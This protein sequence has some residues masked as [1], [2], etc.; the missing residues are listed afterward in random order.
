MKQ[1]TLRNAQWAYAL[2]TACFMAWIAASAIVQEHVYVTCCR[3]LRKRFALL[4]VMLSFASI[5]LP[6][7]MYMPVLSY[8]SMRWRDD[9]N[10]DL[11]L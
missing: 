3:G 9:L 2:H 8:A 6:F 11:M 4:V 1:L 7:V 10:H 5:T